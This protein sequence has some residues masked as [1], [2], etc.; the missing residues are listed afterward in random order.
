M[1]R[2]FAFDP[3]R[4]LPTWDQW[5]QRIHPEDLDKFRM[6]GDRT[7]FEK[8]DCDIEFRIVRPDGTV[9]HI[10]GIGRP[11]LSPSGELVQVVGTMV[12]VTERKRADEARERLRQ[13]EADLAHINRVS[14]MGEL[15]AS[16][17]HE[18]KQPIG[19]AVT[20]AEACVRLLDRDQPDLPEAQEA[21]LEMVRDAKR[22]A[23]IIDHLRSLYQK[24]SP[25]LDIVDVNELVKEMA[26][27][28]HNEAKRHSVAIRTD[29]PEGLPA[30]MADRVQL[31][32]ALMNLMLNGFEAMRDVSGEL[33]IKVQSAQ[34]GQLLIS[35]TDTGVGLPADNVDKIFDAFFTTKVQGTGL[36]LAI[37]RSIIA[38]HGGRIWA[39]PNSG[40]GAT[41][42]FTL[43][44]T[45]AVAA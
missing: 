37:T 19:A 8:I 28:L 32:Q 12:D 5:V 21:A 34:N 33:S 11:V 2:L 40:R 14:T 4:G 22:A 35:V 17:A 6:A 42:H 26:I 27:V 9:K 45:V 15:T 3:Q 16:L 30:V 18:I 24:G 23:D 7:F 29:L 39:T 41:F 36:G 10:H 31:Q 20:N 44:N 25:Q 43:P 1:F 13:L 38:S